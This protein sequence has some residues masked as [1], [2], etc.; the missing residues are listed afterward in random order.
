MLFRKVRRDAVLIFGSGKV[1]PVCHCDPRA[2][3]D[4]FNTDDVIGVD[5][6]ILRRS[7]DEYKFGQGLPSRLNRIRGEISAHNGAIGEQHATGCGALA[8]DYGYRVG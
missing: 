1:S 5:V 2:G 6:S 8:T 4:R 3:P 7:F